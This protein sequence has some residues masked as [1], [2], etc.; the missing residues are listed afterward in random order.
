MYVLSFAKLKLPLL[1]TALRIYLWHGVMRSPIVVSLCL[2][3]CM[4]TQKVLDGFW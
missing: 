1:I 4:I 2:N 3:V